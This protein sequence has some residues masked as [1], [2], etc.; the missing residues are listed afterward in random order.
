[1]FP[2][3]DQVLSPML[4]ALVHTATGALCLKCCVG[5]IAVPFTEN[6]EG[7]LPVDFAPDPA[8]FPIKERA[9]ADAVV[10]LDP[11]TGRKKVRLPPPVGGWAFTALTDPDEPLSIQGYYVT[12]G[13]EDT[14]PQTPVTAMAH[15]DQPIII[16]LATQQIVIS[17]IDL[18]VLAPY[19][20]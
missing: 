8:V 2:T 17:D 15:F 7:E 3:D 9:A 10:V 1:M 19:M 6:K 13:V 20:V 11:I 16:T 12:M 18:E 4:D 14:D 5:L